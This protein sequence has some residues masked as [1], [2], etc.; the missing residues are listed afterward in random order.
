M[1]GGALFWGLRDHICDPGSSKR[2]PQVHQTD[3]TPKESP[4]SEAGAPPPPPLPPLPH[5][6]V[7]R[8]TQKSHRAALSCYRRG[9]AY[10]SQSHHPFPLVP[11]GSSKFRMRQAA[12][13]GAGRMLYQG[14]NVQA[15][16]RAHGLGAGEARLPPGSA[17]QQ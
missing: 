3:S 1:P 12:Q 16:S 17:P 5:I 8:V 15:A 11:R 9:V 6:R 7:A 4:A 2:A 13:K 10:C 14:S